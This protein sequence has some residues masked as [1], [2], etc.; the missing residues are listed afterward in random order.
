MSQDK[1]KT[2][3]AELREPAVRLA[4]E[5]DQSIAQTAKD[6]GVNIN[7]LHPWIGKY[8]RPSGRDKTVSAD[9]HLY[10]ELKHLKKEVARLTEKN[11]LLKRRLRTLPRDDGRPQGGRR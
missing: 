6:L 9:R 5:S 1:S 3:T 11:D 8:S 2:Y 7:I 4:N 10:D